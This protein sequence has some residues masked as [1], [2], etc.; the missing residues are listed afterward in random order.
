M[1]FELRD[2]GLVKLFFADALEEPDAFA[3]LI[4]VNTTKRGA[5]RGSAR[6]PA[7]G[8]ARRG[9]RQRTPLLTL[10]MGIAFHQAMIDLG[11]DF[12]PNPRAESLIVANSAAPCSETLSARISPNLF[13]K[14]TQTTLASIGRIDPNNDSH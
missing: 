13:D 14:S 12:S 1:Q 6:D 5:G 11:D 4:A 2:I 7:R 10:R 8:R 3:L 9:R